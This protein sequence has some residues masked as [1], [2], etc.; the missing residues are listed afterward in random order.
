MT[1]MKRA[2]EVQRGEWVRVGQQAFRVGL[3]TPRRRQELEFQVGRGGAGFYT[4]DS[5]QQ[6][7]VVALVDYAEKARLTAEVHQT[8]VTGR[9]HCGHDACAQR[10]TCAIL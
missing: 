3:I 8:Q 5:D 2:D 7:E 10:R 4:F 9:E 1:T 6:V